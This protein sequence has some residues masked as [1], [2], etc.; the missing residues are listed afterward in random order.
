MKHTLSEFGSLGRTE[1]AARPGRSHP[2]K[3]DNILCRDFTRSVKVRDWHGKSFTY[4]TEFFHRNRF[5]IQDTF[6][7]SAEAS[8]SESAAAVWYGTVIKVACDLNQLVV[9]ETGET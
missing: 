8:L 4:W 1:L 5:V 7:Y 3:R 6:V 2:S 9:Q